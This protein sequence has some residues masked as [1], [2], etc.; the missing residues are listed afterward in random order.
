MANAALVHLYIPPH[1]SL[2]NRCEI[3]D[4]AGTWP[5]GEKRGGGLEGWM[6]WDGG[7]GGPP[8]TS[9]SHSSHIFLDIPS[10][11]LSSL[12]PQYSTFFFY[13]FNQEAN[14]GQSAGGET[15]HS[16]RKIIFYKSRIMSFFLFFFFFFLAVFNQ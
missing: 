5:P 8:T 12:H 10:L 4:M 13:S 1:P 2:A 11:P 6:G 14:S 3:V 7:G 16:P 9:N 15:L